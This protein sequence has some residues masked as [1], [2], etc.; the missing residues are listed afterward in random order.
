MCPPANVV[1]TTG[2]FVVDGI[3]GRN[4]ETAVEGIERMGQD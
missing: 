1:G 4:N 3:K 2:G